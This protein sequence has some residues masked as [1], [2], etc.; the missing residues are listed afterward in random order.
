VC[1]WR[2]TATTRSR[3]TQRSTTGTRSTG[4]RPRRSARRSLGALTKRVRS[5]HSTST[6]ACG[7]GLAQRCWR[8]PWVD[9]RRLGPPMPFAAA[10]RIPDPEA[11]VPHALQA[12]SLV[13]EPKTSELASLMADAPIDLG[14]LLSDADRKDKGPLAALFYSLIETAKLVPP[15]RPCSH[16][17]SASASGGGPRD[18]Y[19][20]STRPLRAAP[21]SHTSASASTRHSAEPLP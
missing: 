4:S 6:R 12:L 10:A 8:L 14:A 20:P 7:R 1:Q 16:H 15:L 11:L 19:I 2:S 13:R 9:P 5:E 3:E 17:I 21:C 18:R